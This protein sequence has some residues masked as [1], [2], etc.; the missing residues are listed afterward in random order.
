MRVF[1]D[2]NVL[3]SAFATR[4]L[5]TDVVQAVLAEHDLVLG[6]TVLKELERTLT[7]KFKAPAQ[8]ARETVEFLESEAVA[9]VRAAKLPGIEMRDSADRRVLGEAIEG[10]A[11]VLVT[12]DKDL[13]EVADEAPMPVVTPR[14]FWD[15]LRR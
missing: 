15:Q 11:D 10:S 2:T 9:V 7:K 6:E 3:V 12:G 5:C 8:T 1:L 4:G 14:G 13:L